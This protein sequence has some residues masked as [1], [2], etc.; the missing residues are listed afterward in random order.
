MSKGVVVVPFDSVVAVGTIL[1]EVSPATVETRC[2]LLPFTAGAGAGTGVDVD[3]DA[4]PCVIGDLDRR[5]LTDTPF[6]GDP[7]WDCRCFLPPVPSSSESDSE[8]SCSLDL[9]HNRS[10]IRSVAL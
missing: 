8:F 7:L 5:F 9:S 1:S 4:L 2:R 6:A 10:A 3:A